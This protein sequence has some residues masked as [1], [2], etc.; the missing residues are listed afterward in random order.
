[1]V[2][3]FTNSAPRVPSQWL[4]D[5][6][7]G[8][9]LKNHSEYMKEREVLLDAYEG[10]NLRELNDVFFTN[11]EG[12]VQKSVP[13]AT[14]NLIDRAIRRR[15][16]VYKNQPDYGDVKW[17]NGYDP[18]KRWQFMKGSERTANNIG[19]VLLRPKVIDGVMDYELLWEYMPFFGENPLDPTGILYSVIVPSAEMSTPKRE[20]VWWTKDTLL[21]MN[22]N[23]KV[24]SQPD[25]PK[26]AN[27]YGMLPFVTANV[28]MGREYWSWGYGKP[29]LDANTAIN[30]AL[31]EM[32]LGVR[33]SMMGQW[34][35]TGEF[36]DKAIVKGTDKVI[37][38][39]TGATLQAIAP[40]A[41]MNAAVEYIKAEYDMTL[42]NIGMKIKFADTGEAQS[43]ISLKI[44]SVELL[45]LRE[46]DVAIWNM[47]DDNLYEKE[48]AVWKVDGTGDLPERTTNF[49]EIEFP[50][51]P[52]EQQGQDQWD[53]DHG[54]TTEALILMREN[55]DGYNTEEEAQ[56]QVNKNKSASV[57]PRVT[58]SAFPTQGRRGEDGGI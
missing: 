24:I 13:S 47:V 34:V 6:V 32:R 48:K 12:K 16:L 30:V 9:K 41:E 22:D 57:P 17:P 23:G 27:R 15:S 36:D 38:L 53:L 49:S 37:K 11:D 58:G 1:M 33:Y 55:P 45:E 21:V 8:L 3:L 26:N 28:R 39:P 19:T 51:T 43:G 4:D 56:E 10:N 2:E 31:T 42:Q 46:D 54:Q 14:Q 35:A 29:L 7:M 20:W 40:P 25:N 44:E 50:K 5:L 18:N 52:E